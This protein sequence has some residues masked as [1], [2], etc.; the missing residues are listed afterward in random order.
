VVFGRW[1]RRQPD[2]CQ[3]AGAS[4]PDETQCAAVRR[5]LTA[6]PARYQTVV[7]L[8]YYSMLS[9]EE[10]AAVVNCRPEAVRKRLSRGLAKLRE[11]LKSTGSREY[12]A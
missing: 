7:V 2:A 10:I 12:E 5:A 9:F 4:E 1:A 6:L 8:R 3:P 11:K